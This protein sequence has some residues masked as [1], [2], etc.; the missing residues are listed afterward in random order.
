MAVVVGRDDTQRFLE[1]NLDPRIHTGSGARTKRFGPRQKKTAS[2]HGAVAEKSS[3]WNQR[4]LP[5]VDDPP[6]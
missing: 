5:C 1:Q 3:A 6:D 4:L 2:D